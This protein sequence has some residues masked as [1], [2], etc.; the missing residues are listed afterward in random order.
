MFALRKDVCLLKDRTLTA[1]HTD[2]VGKLYREFDSLDPVATISNE[3]TRWLKDKDLGGS[4]A[5]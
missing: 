1:L 2:L 3:L 4:A 5:K